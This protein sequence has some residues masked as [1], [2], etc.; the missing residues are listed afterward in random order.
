MAHD[1]DDFQFDAWE[2]ACREYF[3]HFGEGR[4]DPQSQFWFIF[5]RHQLS[6]NPETGA[7]VIGAPGCDGIDFCFRQGLKGVWAYYPYEQLWE[8]KA[9]SLA[10]L[11][12]GWLGGTI[13]V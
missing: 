5:P 2:P 13:T 8:L 3:E 12:E 11:E 1:N 10:D 7:L 6:T 4:Y 9:A